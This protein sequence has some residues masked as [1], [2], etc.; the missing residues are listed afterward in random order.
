MQ[1]PIDLSPSTA[2]RS[3]SLE[4]TGYGYINY[5]PTTTTFK[6]K[7]TTLCLIV[8][9]EGQLQVSYWDGSSLLFNPRKVEFHSPSE[10]SVDGH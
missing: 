2:L 8:N 5:A 10:H 9:G 3:D 6:D 7:G 1:S 4:I